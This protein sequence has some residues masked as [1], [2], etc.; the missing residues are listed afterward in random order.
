[1]LYYKHTEVHGETINIV[2]STQQYVDF[3]F[4]WRHMEGMEQHSMARSLSVVQLD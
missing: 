3:E 1:M 2:E 4:E